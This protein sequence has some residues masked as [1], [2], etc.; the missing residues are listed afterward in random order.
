VANLAATSEEYL[1]GSWLSPDSANAEPVATCA[2]NCPS[3]IDNLAP[4]KQ[5]EGLLKVEPAPN[6]P[7]IVETNVEIVTDTGQ[8]VTR[9]QKAALCRCGHSS[10][11][12]FC[13]G[14]HQRLGFHT[15]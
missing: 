10:K 6:G 15:K 12:P 9:T 5:R 1:K 4:L 2:R 14:T 13:D 3:D 8:T 11:L 7:L